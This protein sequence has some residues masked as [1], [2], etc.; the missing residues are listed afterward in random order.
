MKPHKVVFFSFSFNLISSLVMSLIQIYTQHPSRNIHF[1][2]YYQAEEDKLA[3]L[4]DK[5]SANEQESKHIK[6]NV[7]SMN[8]VSF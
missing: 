2:N 1:F 8:V 3:E 6:A 5:M 4:S 7:A